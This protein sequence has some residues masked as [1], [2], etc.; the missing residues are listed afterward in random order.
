VPMPVSMARLMHANWMPCDGW[1]GRA[2]AWRLTAQLPPDARPARAC[3]P[4]I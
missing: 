2:H 4:A 3:A 1:G